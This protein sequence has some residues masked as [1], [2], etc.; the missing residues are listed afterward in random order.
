MIGTLVISLSLNKIMEVIKSM[1]GIKYSLLCFS[2]KLESFLLVKVDEIKGQNFN[3]E[4][5]K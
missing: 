4:I 5:I 1:H 3:S 2:A